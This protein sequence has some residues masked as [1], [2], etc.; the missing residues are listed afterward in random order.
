MS[1]KLKLSIFLGFFI[2]ILVS[3]S[4][5]FWIKHYKEN[6][7]KK[8]IDK[9]ISEVAPF[10]KVSYKGVEVS[11]FGNEV[12]IKKIEIKALNQENILNI[13]AFI[14]KNL[15]QKH[16]IPY[17]INFYI[18]DAKLNV[19]RFFP[20]Y[21]PIL[22]QFGI[23]SLEF[24]FGVDYDYNP[25]SSRF[26]LNEF[27]LKVYHLGSIELECELVDV[28]PNTN[29]NK[30]F[31]QREIPPF[32]LKYLKLTYKDEGLVNKTFEVLAK[33]KN[34]KPEKLKKE[35]L[36]RL[37]DFSKKCKSE[38]CVKIFTNLLKFLK[39]PN[40]LIFVIQPSNPLPL[41]KIDEI[42]SLKGAEKTLNFNFYAR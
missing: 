37:K 8:S 30:F 19:K 28:S 3:I 13:K 1:N 29:L 35:I 15:D 20:N 21:I 34:T 5:L 10:F 23:K 4:A 26:S 14:I 27:Y 40:E 33:V 22:K 7:V 38:K 16:E 41:S 9:W 32:K 12:K 42:K 17:R 18:K 11:L 25:K 6:Q 24:D 2:V 36:S 39:T 31:S